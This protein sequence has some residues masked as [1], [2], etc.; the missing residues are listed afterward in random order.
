MIERRGPRS[1]ATDLKPL[2]PLAVVWLAGA[3][4]LAGVLGQRTIPYEEL[5]LDPAHYEGRAWYV[6]LISNLGV[7]GWTTATVS[8]AGGGWLARI[9][10]RIGAA[11][12]LRGG[13]LLSGLLLLDDLFQL[14]VVVPKALDLPRTS[15]YGAYVVLTVWWMVG[16]RWELAR[17]RWPLLGAA[18]GALALSVVVDRLGLGGNALIAEDSAKFLGILAWGLYFSLT[19]RDI[20]RSV[21]SD[22]LMST[23]DSVIVPSEADAVPAGGKT[24]QQRA[25]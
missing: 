15:F 17:T 22:L 2:A 18:L 25:D 3:I 16:S 24:D 14:H 8:A 1:W 19:G 11:E 23:L 9:A 6:G 21:L 10:G 12:M 5:L 13:A 4:L 7:L 20:A